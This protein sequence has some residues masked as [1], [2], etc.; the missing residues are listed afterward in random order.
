MMTHHIPG[1]PQTNPI[2]LP[3]AAHSSPSGRRT[4]VPIL[5]NPNQ[6]AAPASAEPAHIRE[7]HFVSQNQ[8]A[9]LHDLDGIENI[10]VDEAARKAAAS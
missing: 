7:V 8:R 1:P 9:Q 3:S 10:D 4:P 6:N 5:F 2:S